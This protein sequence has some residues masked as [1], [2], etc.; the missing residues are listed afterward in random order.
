M[1]DTPTPVRDNTKSEVQVPMVVHVF[2]PDTLFFRMD[3]GDATEPDGKKW[4]LS[5]NMGSGCP[6]VR[7]PDGRWVTLTWDAIITAAREA[8]AKVP[9]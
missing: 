5:T 3:C 8:L 9:K 4:E 7:S 1:T 2:G 6:I